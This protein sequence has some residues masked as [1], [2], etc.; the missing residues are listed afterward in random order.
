M[1]DEDL[2]WFDA[3]FTSWW[4]VGSSPATSPSWAMVWDLFHFPLVALPVPPRY[5]LPNSSLDSCL[6]QTSNI[7]QASLAVLPLK[8]L[9]LRHSQMAAASSQVGPN[10]GSHARDAIQGSRTISLLQ[11]SVGGILHQTQIMLWDIDLNHWSSSCLH[12]HVEGL[13]VT[14][15]GQG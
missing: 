8:N 14:D 15:L 11:S 10:H 2:E 13:G 1:S 12:D 5:T 7:V 3:S 9:H 4:G 6:A